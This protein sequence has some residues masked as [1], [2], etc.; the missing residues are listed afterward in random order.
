[1]VF[2]ATSLCSGAA[3]PLPFALEVTVEDIAAIL[4]RGNSD[5]VEEEKQKR[6]EG[7]LL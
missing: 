5:D 6:K 1:M 4:C 2:S 7:A 3:G